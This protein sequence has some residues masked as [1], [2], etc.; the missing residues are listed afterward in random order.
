VRCI[1][2]ASLTIP[3]TLPAELT[4]GTGTDVIGDQNVG[5]I[6]NGAVFVDGDDRRNHD[7]SCFHTTLPRT[8]I[9]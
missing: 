9:N 6:A 1:R 2:S 3:T 7:V 8:E 5:Q 4:T